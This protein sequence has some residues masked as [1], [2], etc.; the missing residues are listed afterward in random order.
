M[1]LLAPNDDDFCPCGASKKYK[2]CHGNP[3]VTAPPLKDDPNVDP[4]LLAL[5][6]TVVDLLKD[7]I[8]A[9]KVPEISDAN[10]DELFRKRTLLYFAKKV[11]RVTMAGVTL[12]RV[13]QSTQALTLKRDQYN[14]W[15][16]FFHYFQNETNSVLFIASGPLRQRDSLKEIM[17][18][19]ESAKADPK[20]QNQLKKHEENAQ[21]LYKRFPGLQVPKGKSGET[22]TPILIDWSEPS[23]FDMMRLNR[24]NVA[25][26]A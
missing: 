23:E 8:E 9:V 5:A 24:E 13:G 11:Y 3:T 2:R 6:Y 25:R 26:R 18:F 21:R 7:A 16:A 17:A 10:A 19:D 14:A 22:T 15:V 4:I 20:R 12:L 1:P